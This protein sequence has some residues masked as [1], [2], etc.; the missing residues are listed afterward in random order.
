MG[1][2]FMLHDSVF[3]SALVAL[4]LRPPFWGVGFVQVLEL[5]LVPPPQLALQLLQGDQSDQFPS[6][7]NKKIKKTIKNKK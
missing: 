3:D 5:V 7:K 1:H 4:Q 6:F 2:G